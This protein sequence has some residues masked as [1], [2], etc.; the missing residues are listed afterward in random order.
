M[1]T[2]LN[3]DSKEF[4]SW[5]LRWYIEVLFYGGPCHPIPLLEKD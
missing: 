5:F 1:L 2:V 3:G 4:E